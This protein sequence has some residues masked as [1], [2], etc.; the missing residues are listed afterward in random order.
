M[1][2]FSS[3][4]TPRDAAPEDV[5]LIN[6]LA[7]EVKRDVGPG[8]EVGDLWGFGWIALLEVKET[9]DPERGS[10]EAYAYFRVKGAMLDGCRKMAGLT[11]RMHQKRRDAEARLAVSSEVAGQRE[12]RGAPTTVDAAGQSFDEIMELATAA[13]ITNA[14]GSA[15]RHGSVEDTMHAEIDAK[16]IVKAMTAVDVRQHR[17]L[18]R[19]YWEDRSLT[20]I[21]DELKLGKSG[22]CRVHTAALRAMRETLGPDARR[23]QKR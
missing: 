1:L 19:F 7:A 16:R 6:R 11:Y 9:F 23:V 14:V 5:Q 22:A 20:E 2:A 18:T 13:A 4:V 12:L 3:I 21:G 8:A 10:F 17:L 15:E